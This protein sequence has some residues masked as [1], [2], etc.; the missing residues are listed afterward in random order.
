MQ[1]KYLALQLSGFTALKENPE[2]HGKSWKNGE[3]R[4]NLENAGKV[5]G[6][7]KHSG[8]NSREIF[9]FRSNC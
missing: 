3:I 8:E 9:N 6:K 1:K 5:L 4:K 2:N 7:L